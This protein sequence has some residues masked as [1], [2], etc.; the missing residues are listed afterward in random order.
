VNILNLGTGDACI[1]NDSVGWICERLGMKPK[2]T[3]SGGERGWIGDNPVIQL[4]VTRIRGLGWSP[5][6]NI[7]E[8][9]VRTV[10]WLTANPWALDGRH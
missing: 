6:F 7:R 4:D 1:V 2:L 5:K 8:G 10:D 3:Y 9:V